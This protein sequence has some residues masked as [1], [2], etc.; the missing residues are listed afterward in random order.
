M[1]DSN[2]TNETQSRAG[3]GS[4]R[5]VPRG[6]SGA[7]LRLHLDRGAPEQLHV[8]VHRALLEAMEGGVLEPGVVLPSTRTLATQLGVA[9]STVAR[10]YQH[11]REE[12]L[13]SI[14]RGAPPRVA[15]DLATRLPASRERSRPAV[16]VSLDLVSRRGRRV[17]GLVNPSFPAVPR[18]PR[19][20][21]VSVPAVDLF[22]VATWER[23]VARVMRRTPA[24]ALTYGDARG[25]PELRAAIAEHLGTAHGIRTAPEHVLVTQGSQQAISLA[26]HMLTDPGDT[27]LTE[28]PGYQAVAG[29]GC[30]AG[31]EVGGMPV[32]W[33][34]ANLSLGLRAHPT[35]RLAVV[36][37][38][39]HFTLGHT[40]SELRRRELLQWSLRGNWVIEDDYAADL[41]RADAPL[42][43]RARPEGGN[44]VYVG[45]F[46]KI[47]FPALRMGF[48][49]LPPPLTEAFARGRSY[50]DLSPP[51]LEQ[52]AL[53]AFIREGHLSRHVRRV[54]TALGERRQA[55]VRILS[56][57]LGSLGRLEAPEGLWHAILWLPDGQDP[58]RVIR[59][60]AE[61]GVDLCAVDHFAPT[62]AGG[63]RGLLIGFSGLRV[64]EIEA[65]AVDLA[66]ALRAAAGTSGSASS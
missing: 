31:A 57:L 4:P 43:L 25:L 40:M 26:L 16:S 55:L 37:P 35:A 24:P 20:F 6:R 1:I 21:R 27:I 23:T 17:A 3:A 54:V 15:G 51:Y 2:T 48:L 36:S 28:E 62:P 59:L 49:V 64:D 11:L 29:A 22:P 33:Q 5:S 65:A 56:P 50:L 34:G 41:R 39:Q 32:D 18:A 42:A 60:A 10:A 14:R 44:V 7:L 58:A 8:G 13:L 63:G 66:A 47:L 45:T 61:R 30:L 38:G 53:A 19:P 12:G 46:S 9:R 52:A